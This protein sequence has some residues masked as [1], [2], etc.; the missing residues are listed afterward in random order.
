MLLIKSVIFKIVLFRVSIMNKLKFS[1]AFYLTCYLISLKEAACI[2]CP[3]SDN[4]L[5]NTLYTLR[6]C[7]YQHFLSVWQIVLA[8]RIWPHV[9]TLMG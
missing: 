6:K 5:F 9:S 8:H 7:D 4:F 3:I 2:F 1:S